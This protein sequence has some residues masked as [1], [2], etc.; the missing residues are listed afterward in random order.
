MRL[1]I[2]FCAIFSFS[3]CQNNTTTQKETANN[4]SAIETVTEPEETVLTNTYCFVAAE[5]EGA[6]K[7]TTAVKL[8][9]VGKEVTGSYNWIPVGT[10]SARGTLTGSINNGIIT[11]IYDYVIEGSE[12]KQEMIFKMKVNQLL[13]KKGI[14]ED[15]GGIMKLKD[16][17]NAKFSEII[18]RVL[19]K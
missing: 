15:V 11:A 18:P 12:Q 17:D 10:H 13:V 16:P 9:I 8:V 19:C 6:Y 3:A 5:G 1:I 7:D 2:L 4:Y 14:L